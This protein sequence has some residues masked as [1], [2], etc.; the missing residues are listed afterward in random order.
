MGQGRGVDA[1]VPLAPRDETASSGPFKRGTHAPLAIRWFG[2][3]ALWG[4]LRH[5]LAVTAASNQLDLRDWMRPEAP[6]NLLDRVG[7][8]LA[9][10]PQGP[11]LAERLGREVWIDFVADTGDDHDLS[12]AV[13]RM[14]FAEYTLAGPHARTLPRGDLLIFGGDTA[15]PA[16]TAHELERRL[17]EPWNSVIAGKA[18]DD[19]ASSDAR[20]SRQSRLVRRP[21]RVRASLS[22]ERP[23]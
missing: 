20:D 19:T 8:V 14:L 1:V 2:T 16:A 10:Q 13:G 17:L 4:H 11:S 5:L 3:T 9:A 12:V 7:R 22:P 6:E 18:Q 15:Y 21:R 23:R